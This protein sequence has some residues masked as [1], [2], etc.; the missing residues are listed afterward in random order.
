MRR[1]TRT[2]TGGPPWKIS[3][4]RSI[5]SF[6]AHLP[7][8]TSCFIVQFYAAATSLS[9][10][11]LFFLDAGHCGQLDDGEHQ[12][13]CG[14][15]T[16]SRH[17][18]A[19]ATLGIIACDDKNISGETLRQRLINPLPK[20][21]RLVVVV[22]A[23]HSGALLALGDYV[24]Q[25][26]QRQRAQSFS[27]SMRPKKRTPLPRRKSE[28]GEMLRVQPSTSFLSLPRR[29]FKKAITTT[30][31]VIRFKSTLEKKSIEDENDAV[32]PTPTGQP[33]FCTRCHRAFDFSK[34]PVVIFLSA[35]KKDQQTWEDTKRRG[36]GMTTKLLK[37]L[38]K[39]PSI[40]LGELE[41][42]LNRCLCKLSFKR[43]KKAIAA[44]RDFSMSERVSPEQKEKLKNKYQD[45]GVFDFR[46]QSAQVGS[47]RPVGQNERFLQERAEDVPHWNVNPFLLPSK[48]AFG[49]Q[50][51]RSAPVYFCAWR[52]NPSFWPSF[53]PRISIPSGRC[54]TV[55]NTI[56]TRL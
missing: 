37:I 43:V 28:G 53:R 56:A 44:F 18:K 21:S 24:C 25:C 13:A 34:A 14:F 35:C 39:E 52:T 4:G 16:F 46:D 42:R 29:R 31:A 5:I 49:A 20:D 23:C 47:L 9:L 32:P 45:R 36:K 55:K 7:V 50:C 26:T 6:A 33:Q 8:I 38:R 54:H 27:E 51:C 22:D 30:L 19:I 17:D 11:D 3:C 48:F 12:C 2:R 40:K 15:F 1:G 41:R 10:V